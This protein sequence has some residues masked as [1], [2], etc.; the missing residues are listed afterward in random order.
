[1]QIDKQSFTTNT[2]D[3]NGKKVLNWPRMAN[4]G[5]AKSI[6]IGDPHTPSQ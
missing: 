6:I 1:M 4:K 2:L 3:M 5:K